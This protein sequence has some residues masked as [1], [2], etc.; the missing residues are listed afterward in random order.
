MLNI[1]SNTEYLKSCVYRQNKLSDHSKPFDFPKQGNT[2]DRKIQ[3]E[4]TLPLVSHKY[5]RSMVSSRIS[6]DEVSDI[7]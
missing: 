3:P 1:A 4:M 2:Q 5:P 7:N 6:D